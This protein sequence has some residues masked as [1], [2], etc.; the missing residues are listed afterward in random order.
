MKGGSHLSYSP[1]TM[2][3]SSSVREERKG[4]RV[5]PTYRPFEEGDGGKKKRAMVDL[6]F[7]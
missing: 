5:T 6:S 2:W 1:S 7:S 3:E 4:E